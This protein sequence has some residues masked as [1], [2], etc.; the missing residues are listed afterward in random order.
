MQAAEAVAALTALAQE[1][2]LA[3]FRL[4]VRRGEDGLPAGKIAESLKVPPPTLSFHLAQLG[5]AGLVRS[6]REGR[7]VTYSADF[8]QMNALLQYLTENCCADGACEPV[9][10]QRKES[11][12]SDRKRSRSK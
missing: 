4:L 8:T 6:R 9:R 12:V 1:S 11:H 7:Q 2:R 10:I 3:V 5:H